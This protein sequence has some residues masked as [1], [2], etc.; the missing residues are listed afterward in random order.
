MQKKA[1]HLSCQQ[2]FYRASQM[3]LD[4]GPALWSIVQRVRTKGQIYQWASRF[5]RPEHGNVLGLEQ[6]QNRTRTDLPRSVSSQPP[7]WLVPGEGKR[8]GDK[9][10]ATRITEAERPQWCTLTP[11]VPSDPIYATSDTLSRAPLM[12]IQGTRKLECPR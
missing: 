12:V 1:V 2:D 5:H 9:Q 3:I 4:K 6:A 11:M 10:G 8:N 7:G